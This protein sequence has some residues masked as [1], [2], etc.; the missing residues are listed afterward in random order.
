MSQDGGI[1]LRLDAARL[2]LWDK[3]S[4]IKK[5]GR[6]ALKFGLHHCGL[7]DPSTNELQLNLDN[8]LAVQRQTYIH[9]EIGE[10]E[11]T[12]FC[13]E[14]WQEII[15][16]FPHTPIELSARSVK[17]L[18]A[19]TGPKGS[20]QDIINRKDAAALG[21]FVAFFDGLGKEFFPE[22]PVAFQL[23]TTSGDWQVIEEAA[24]AGRRTARKHAE[25]MT[26]VFR[27]GQNRQDLQWAAEEIKTRLFCGIALR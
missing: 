10:I 26:T 14:T 17:D 1:I 12:I 11:D 6:P 3:I 19:D 4:Y 18:L 24:E 23:F 16:A 13:R 22:L 27:E 5:S 25:T 9:H 7:E 21:L 2:F 8:I 15:A 20:L